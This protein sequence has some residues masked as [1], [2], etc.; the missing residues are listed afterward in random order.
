[1]YSKT[2]E[3]VATIT[4]LI[5]QRIESETRAITD[6]NTICDDF[7]DYSY[8]DFKAF[9][10]DAIN[11][12][13]QQIFKTND[14]TLS[15]QQIESVYRLIYIYLRSKESYT[16]F[17]GLVFVGFGEEEIYPRLLPIFISL[18]IQ[19][20]LRYYI[21][22][23]GIAIISNEN[24]GAVA[25][26]AQHDVMDTILK[27][28]DDN[29]HG[30]YLKNF[31]TSLNGQKEAIAQSIEHLNPAL[32]IEIRALDSQRFIDEYRQN[33][34]DAMM[35]GY[36]EPMLYFTRDKL[37]DCFYQRIGTSS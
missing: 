27:G 36:I 16:N 11:A 22:E 4:N 8:D 25:P 23:G 9:S 26:F 13:I 19:D 28:V 30:A 24:S 17:T 10:T 3:N 5:I 33:N 15:A 2:P 1:M 34:E 32:A 18:S 21:N 6:M 20:R 35:E 37:V 31:E 7:L 29:L 12:V 14:L